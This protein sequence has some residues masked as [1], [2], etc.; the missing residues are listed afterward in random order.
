MD[1]QVLGP[2]AALHDDRPVPLGGARQQRILAALLND[3]NHVV[4]VSKLMEAVWRERPTT[5]R[6]Q[7]QI[8][9]S[10]LRRSIEQSGG[11]RMIHT[12][13]SGYL[14]RLEHE[15]LDSAVFQ[16]RVASGQALAARGAPD[17]ACGELWSALR[18][19]RGPA[20]AGVRDRPVLKGWADA[21]EQARVA[22]LDLCFRV[23]LRA[24][25]H[26]RILPDLTKAAAENPMHEGIQGSLMQALY[27][28]QRQADALSVYHRTRRRLIEQLGVEPGRQLRRLEYEILSGAAEDW[29]VP[30]PDLN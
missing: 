27:V 11:G 26:A 4:P 8:A 19:W 25:Q 23:S 20:L 7:V 14:L 28:S 29:A 10:R 22:A 15:Q 13:P 17:E 6:S 5:V 21:L 18:M 30:T 12:T 3:A 16:A 1:F 9:V 24:G 2:V